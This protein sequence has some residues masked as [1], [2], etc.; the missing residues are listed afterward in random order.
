MPHSP[1]LLARFCSPDLLARLADPRRTV[2][3]CTCCLSAAEAGSECQSAKDDDL[4]ARSRGSCKRLLKLH[5][6]TRC[7][8]AAHSSDHAFSAELTWHLLMGCSACLQGKQAAMAAKRRAD[9]TLCQTETEL[10]ELTLSQPPS[11][12]AV[13]LEINS[14][15]AQVATLGRDVQAAEREV[16]PLLGVVSLS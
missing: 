1:D 8:P 5:V 16:C 7:P 6:A 12:D 4:P 13:D 14:L 11:T 3:Q 15:M 9:T 2:S 10:R